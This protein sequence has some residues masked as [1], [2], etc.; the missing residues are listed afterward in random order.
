MRGE[1]HERREAREEQNVVGEALNHSS[2]LN[3]KIISELVSEFDGTPD[4]FEVWERQ[5][6]FM[7]APYRLAD[8]AAKT[9]IGMKVRKKAFG[10]LHSK[11]EQLA[12]MFYELMDELGRIY[13]PKQNKIDLRRKFEARVWKKGVTFREY[14]HDKIIIGYRIPIDDNDFLDYLID[15]DTTELHRFL[16]EYCVISRV[17]SVSQQKKL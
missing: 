11:A 2:L 7:K 1:S 6:R 9:L 14:V 12:M 5:I 10:W 16:I 3:L 4:S 13:Y 17:Y 8:D 15:G